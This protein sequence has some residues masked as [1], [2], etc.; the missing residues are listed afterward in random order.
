M[1]I[2][3]IPPGES[4]ISSAAHPGFSNHGFGVN[5]ENREIDPKGLV[6]QTQIQE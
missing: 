6:A 3:N 4:R 1:K 5:H 2:P